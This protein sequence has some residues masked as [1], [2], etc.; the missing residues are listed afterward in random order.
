MGGESGRPDADT[1]VPDSQWYG[2]AKAHINPDLAR[3]KVQCIGAKVVDA[4]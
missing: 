1:I 2:L 4:Q 3:I